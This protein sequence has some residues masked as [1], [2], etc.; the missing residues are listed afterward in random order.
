ME[1]MWIRFDMKVE[2]RSF[3]VRPYVGGVNGISG[4][5]VMGG[6]TTSQMSSISEQQDYIV[7][8]EQKW[9][10]GIATTPGVVRQFVATKMVPL[11]LTECHRPRSTTLSGGGDSGAGSEDT[12]Y[13]N[14]NDSP[15]ATVEWQI[16][17]E[18]NLGGIQLQLIPDFNIEK[19]SATSERDVCTL[20]RDS[21][22]LTFPSRGKAI[23]NTY[24]VLKT[25][26]E[27]GLPVGSVI[28]IK[29]MAKRRS[30]RPKTIMDLIRESPAN[31]KV[32]DVIELQVRDATHTREWKFNIREQDVAGSVVSFWVSESF[33]A[34]LS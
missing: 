18:D 10:N 9:L 11:R 31:L 3:A 28:H 27:L 21:E 24:D 25:P 1:A 8:P 32:G 30:S 20:G 22:L 12:G 34:T 19:M 6:E 16:T 5:P 26:K 29:D 17:G 14:S 33:S 23:A 2:G 15:G 7:L 4:K 13:Y